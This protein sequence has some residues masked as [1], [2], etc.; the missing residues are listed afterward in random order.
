MFLINVM[1]VSLTYEIILDNTNTMLGKKRKK[2]RDVIWLTLY[3][4]IQLYTNN[5]SHIAY[6]VKF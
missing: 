6:P 4:N 2:K 1:L 5:T 3:H